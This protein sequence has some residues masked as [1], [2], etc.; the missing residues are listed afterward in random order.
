M[1]DKQTVTISVFIDADSKKHI[2]ASSSFVE[3]DNILEKHFTST[4]RETIRW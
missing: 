2:K 3:A 1:Q 4:Y